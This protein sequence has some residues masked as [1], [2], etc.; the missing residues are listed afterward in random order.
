MNR[1][2]AARVVLMSSRATPRVATMTPD[3]HF[4]PKRPPR[5]MLILFLFLLC[6]SMA[7]AQCGGQWLSPISLPGIF[8]TT[9]GGGF[10]DAAIYWDPDGPGPRPECLAV[11]GLFNRA[12][13]REA[14]NVALW[15][16]VEWEPLS[17]GLSGRVNA[18]AVYAGD[19]IAGGSFSI[20]GGQPAAN[21]ARWDGSAWH[22]LGDG[23]SSVVF[24]FCVYEGDLI[25]AGDFATADGLPAGHIARWDGAQWHVLSSGTDGTVYALTV[26]NGDLIASGYFTTAGGA[27]ANNI[28]RWGGAA[29]TPLGPGIEVPPSPYSGGVRSLAAVQGDL[30]AAANYTSDPSGHGYYGPVV[31]WDGTSWSNF[32]SVGG[33]MSMAT[34]GGQLV[35]CGNNFVFFGGGQYTSTMIVRSWDGSAWQ[36]LGPTHCPNCSM[37]ATAAHAITTSGQRLSVAGAFASI[38]GTP[39]LSISEWSDSSWHGFGETVYW[40]GGQSPQALAI[41]RG[42]L[43]AAGGLF[44]TNVEISRYD[45]QHWQAFD[46]GPNAT[47]NALALYGSDLVAGGAFDTIYARPSSFHAGHIARWNGSVWS[48][49]GPEPNGTVAA[50]L[51]LPD[52]NLVAAGTFTSAGGLPATNIARWN[53]S[54]AAW[55]PLGEGL[56]GGP[57]YPARVA[58]LSLYN[59]DIIAA[60]AFTSSGASTLNHI[61]RWDPTTAQWRSLGSGMDSGNVAALTVFQGDLVAAGTFA[62]AGGV[63][64]SRIARWNGSGWQ[65]IGAGFTGFGPFALS[66]YNGQLV[67]GGSLTTSGGTPTPGAAR[68][69]GAAWEGIGGGINCVVHAFAEYGGEL[70]AI[71]P[72][73]T[74]GFSWVHWSPTNI[75]WLA[76]QSSSIPSACPGSQ[77]SFT[78]TPAFGY[79]DLSYQ[80]QRDNQPLAGGPTPTGSIIAGSQT[81]T[82]TISNISAA[83]AATYTC[84]LSNSCGQ[85]LSSPA[86]LSIC[87]ADLNCDDQLNLLDFLSFLQ[88]FSQADPRAD[89]NADSQI[90]VSDFVAFLN[91]F[92]AGC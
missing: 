26:Y 64:A 12:G 58:S 76:A 45:G 37:Y 47:V 9:T 43:V 44:Y 15:N 57:A 4:R 71:G 17:S 73:P 68:W 21:I 27:A 59:G 53:A 6:S 65:P 50:L 46:S 40:P 81:Q 2:L 80:W 89:F 48:A 32:P 88:L 91:A 19:L 74:D 33:E 69:T 30:I 72:Q 66:T 24:S 75:P 35:A 90:N 49:W 52:G 82:L 23:V 28:A 87:P 70:H 42:E 63:P 60:G 13:A 11:G 14:S 83:D 77:A 78:V 86:T 3:P 18:L 56:Q 34:F 61:A 85:A 92:A 8:T 54:A 5:R 51:P 36:P 67:A 10:S 25:A 1:S 7:A 55:E 31:R 22:T 16:G 62:S 29:W 20:A 84:L 41:Y 38:D 79:H 39:A